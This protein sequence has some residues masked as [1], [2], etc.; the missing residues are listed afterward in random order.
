MSEQ[1]QV[2]ARR[3][4]EKKRLSSAQVEQLLDEAARSGRSFRDVALGRGLVSAQDFQPIPPRQ[5]P[6]PLLILLGAGLTLFAI[7]LVNS[8]IERSRAKAATTLPT[9]SPK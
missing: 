2:F 9:L 4:L 8:T 7:L 5:I 6:L 3:L 1:D